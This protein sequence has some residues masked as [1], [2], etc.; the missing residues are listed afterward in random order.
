MYLLRA[1]IKVSA[2]WNSREALGENL[3]ADVQVVCRM[4]FVAV[5]GPRSH[6]RWLSPW[7]HSQLLEAVIF[8][9]TRSPSPSNQQQVFGSLF[10]FRLLLLP[11]RENACDYKSPLCHIMWHNYGSSVSS[12]SQ[13]PHPHSPE[14]GTI[15]EGR[16]V[17]IILRILPTMEG[18]LKWEPSDIFI[19][20][21]HVWDREEKA[22]GYVAC[23]FTLKKKLDVLL[24]T[25]IFT[26]FV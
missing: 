7:G 15:Q 2:R 18:R 13:I 1:E 9:I 11:A 26:I 12:Q 25:T 24:I 17:G 23:C 3:L 16:S 21:L 22:I 5:V 10:S 14:E 19:R 20:W 4:Q 8:P 6:F